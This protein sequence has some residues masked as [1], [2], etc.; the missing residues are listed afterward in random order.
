MRTFKR[1]Y[2]CEEENRGW[3]IDK[4]EAFDGETV[5]GYIKISYIP[6]ENYN[7]YYA[8][9]VDYMCR[10]GG[11]GSY[12]YSNSSV[13]TYYNDRKFLKSVTWH[14]WT[15]NKLHESIDHLTDDECFILFKCL[16]KFVYQRYK[17]NIKLFQA[18]WQNRP[19]VDYISVLPKYRRQGIGTKLYIEAGKMMQEKGL[20]LR[21]ST[22][23]S[24][25]A[26]AVWQ[27]LTERNQTVKRGKYTYLN[28]N[29]V[30]SSN[31]G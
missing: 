5:I 10:I 13:K 30:N 11:W 2:N 25:E 8:S 19:M 31:V 22:L 1:S 12:R 17:K 20:Q 26:K 24:D 14:A 29:A 27:R 23:Q 15:D 21:A 6:K 4:V 7:K 18:R 28:V 3:V 9:P 16:E